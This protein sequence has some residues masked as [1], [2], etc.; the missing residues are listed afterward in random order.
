MKR[1][2]IK[3]KIQEKLKM[4]LGMFIPHVA[5]TIIIITKSCVVSGDTGLINCSVVP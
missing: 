2:I 3:K 1:I 5:G 4:T